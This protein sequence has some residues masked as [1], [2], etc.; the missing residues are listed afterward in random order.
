VR[1]LAGGRL[2]PYEQRAGVGDLEA[3]AHFII[4]SNIIPFSPATSDGAAKRSLA[5]RVK[6]AT[7]GRVDDLMRSTH[8]LMSQ[9]GRDRASLA[10]HVFDLGAAE[11]GGHDL[12]DFVNGEVTAEAG[13]RQAERR[14][15][16]S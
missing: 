7:I 5:D 6:G 14:W 13:Q 10:D 15:T 11:L 1:V 8:L 3:G 9:A 2:G 16:R 12:Y 4:A